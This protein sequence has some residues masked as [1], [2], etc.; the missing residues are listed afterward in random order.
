MRKDFFL[1]TSVPIIES[2]YNFVVNFEDLLP[3][4]ITLDF[5]KRPSGIKVSSTKGIPLGIKVEDVKPF[6][7]WDIHSK[8]AKR[9][10]KIQK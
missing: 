2:L 3:V 9:Q 7:G 6:A 1:A 4:D 10:V 8:P 5:S